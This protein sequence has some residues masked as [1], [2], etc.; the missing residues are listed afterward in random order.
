[1]KY[2]STYGSIKNTKMYD[3]P[4]E[5]IALCDDERNI[6]I[7]LDGVSR[8]KIN[9][10]YPNPSPAKEVSELFAKVSYDYLKKRDGKYELNH[11]KT[12]FIK[13]NEAIERYNI[14]YHGFLP[15][16]VGIVCCIYK[17]KL[18]YGYIGDCYGRLIKTDKVSIFTQCQTDKIV[19]HKR[20]YNSEEIRNKI[21]NN[22]KHP[23]GYG[24]LTGQKEALDFIVFGEY[25]LNNVDMIFLSSDGMESFL[26]RLS[27]KD[28]V[29]TDA[30]YYLRKS[31]MRED[32]DKTI[33]II[34]KKKN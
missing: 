33:I 26:T 2:I 28:F 22:V 5:D 14:K 6:Y 7:L 19:T 8:D 30:S 25:Y 27:R 21:C 3:K 17:D 34:L 4:N 13:G 1:M 29:R 10:K 15:G 12:A 24:V 20:E 9:G 23:Y 18:Y 11:V 16:T 32:D 31:V